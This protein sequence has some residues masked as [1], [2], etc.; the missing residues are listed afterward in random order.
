[1][2][3]LKVILMPLEEYKRKRD[4]SKTVEPLGRVKKSGMNIFVVQ[5]HHATNL[6]YDFRLEVEGVLRSWAVP[7]GVPLRHGV[8]RLAVATEDHPLDYADFEGTIP[9]GEYGAGAVKI[10]DRGTYSPDKITDREII[11][12]LNGGRL[13]GKYVL[14]RLKDRKNWLLFRKK[15]EGK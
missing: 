9:E 12:E 5:E 1:M 10:W 4:F 2:V 8:K 7:K 14:I 6:H 15:E 3:T 11:A 13:K